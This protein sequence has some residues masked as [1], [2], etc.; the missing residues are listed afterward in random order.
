MCDRDL[1]DYSYVQGAFD[2]LKS[3][4]GGLEENRQ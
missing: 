1:L 3:V 2:R 4:M